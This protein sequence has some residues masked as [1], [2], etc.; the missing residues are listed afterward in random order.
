MEPLDDAVG[1]WAP[2]L[3]A[4]VVDVLDRQIELVFMAVVGPAIFGP[5]VC[6]DALQG[7]WR[8]P[9]RTGSPGP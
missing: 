1:L 9:R 2:G 8:A 4:G 5:T 6:E 7:G 3:G